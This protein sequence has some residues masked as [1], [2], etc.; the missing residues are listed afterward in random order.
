MSLVFAAIVPH[1]PL[2]VPNI[3]KQSIKKIE[4]TKIALEQLEKDIYVTRPEI[5]VIISPHGSHFSEAFT[6]NVSP[7][8][9]TDLREFG[10]LGTKIKFRGETHLA[11]LIREGTKKENFAAAMISERNLDHGSSVPL[12][13][14]AKHLKNIKII[15]IGFCDLDW[16]THVAF[17]SMIAEKISEI[18]KRV[19]VIASGDLSHA[20][21]TEAPAGSNPAGPEFD[22]KIQELL[23]GNNLSGML[24]LDKKFVADAAECGFRSFLILMGILHGVN[25]T[26]KSYAYEGPFGVG[27][28]TS[29]FSL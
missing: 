21:M 8:Y 24:Q 16:K 14:L 1:S 2:L 25:H 18:N 17:G 20:L 5:L 9:Q 7:E 29:K 12:L 22:K 26:Y 11:A 28:L 13:Y 19:A 4:K 6:I 10:D 23:A 15:Q 27:Y 3:G